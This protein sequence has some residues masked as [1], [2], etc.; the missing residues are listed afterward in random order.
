M[1]PRALGSDELSIALGEAMQKIFR[2]IVTLGSV[3]F[4]LTLVAYLL[5]N[6]V[7][8]LLSGLVL[9]ALVVLLCGSLI[10]GLLKWRKISNVWPMPAIVCLAFILCSFYV[11]SPI[12]RY[13]SDRRFERH[14]GTYARVV[15][16]FRNGSVRCTSAC[17]G[18]AKVIATG[19]IPAH[20]RDVWGMHC[21]GN[22]VIV[23]FRLDTH[24][25]LL[26]EGYMFRDYGEN[27]NCSKRFGS[28]E[29]VW[30]HLPYVRQIE[31]N[32]YRFSD[33]PGF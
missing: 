20:V 19:N 30:S 16:D 25:P 4:V 14:L 15:K 6:F 12:G 27:S 22:S 18:V 23:L 31:G 28:H 8:L 21:E 10:A 2:W 7:C 26:H 9:L 13:I 5:P 17:D 33:Q 11:A 1:A 32:W 24:V 29:F 3:L